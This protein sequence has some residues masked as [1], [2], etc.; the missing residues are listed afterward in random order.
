MFGK[1]L[2]TSFWLPSGQSTIRQALDPEIL[3]LHGPLMNGGI[4]FRSRKY[5][6]SCVGMSF[7][8]YQGLKAYMSKRVFLLSFWFLIFIYMLLE[9]ACAW[10]SPWIRPPV[11]GQNSCLLENISSWMHHFRIG[12]C[13]LAGKYLKA[14]NFIAF[15]KLRFSEAECL[16]ILN[17]R[18]WQ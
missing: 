13:S 7:L 12:S 14:L 8:F 11:F 17:G 2:S 18:K 3:T 5:G 1:H 10:F 4:I 6:S 16:V 15:G 9:C